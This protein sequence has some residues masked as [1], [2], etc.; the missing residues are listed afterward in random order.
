MFNYNQKQLVEYIKTEK[1]IFKMFSE[2][3]ASQLNSYTYHSYVIQYMFA[4]QQPFLK[5]AYF[6]SKVP[7]D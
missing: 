1:K 3:V 6:S 5:A 7:N 4:E 2:Y